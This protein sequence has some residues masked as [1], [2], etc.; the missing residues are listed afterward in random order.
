MNVPK[1]CITKVNVVLDCARRNRLQKNQMR[2]QIKRKEYFE[3]LNDSIDKMRKDNQQLQCSTIELNKL[4]HCVK[5]QAAR[6]RLDTILHFYVLFEFGILDT[7]DQLKFVNENIK[8]EVTL[9][10]DK[11]GRKTFW[12]QMVLRSTLYTNVQ[13]E[14]VKADVCGLTHEIIDVKAKV[15]LQLNRNVIQILYHNLQ[16]QFDMAQFLVGKWMT[17]DV[18]QVYYFRG[19]KIQSISTHCNWINAWRDLCANYTDIW[20]ILKNA[21]ID[22]HLFIHFQ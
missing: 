12:N 16:M 6:A 7:P 2:H 21:N 14:I 5:V 1:K 20:M 18:N 3:S 9:D 15:H 11:R 17:L 22:Q 13:F 19:P 10:E 4:V 8:L